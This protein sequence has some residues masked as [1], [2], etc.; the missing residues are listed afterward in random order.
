MVVLG[1]VMVSDV[2]LG[3]KIFMELKVSLGVGKDGNRVGYRVV[4]F[5]I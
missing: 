5:D 1:R 2:E 4:Y 3:V